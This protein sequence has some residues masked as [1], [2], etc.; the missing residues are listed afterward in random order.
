MGSNAEEPEHSRLMSFEANAIRLPD[1]DRPIYR[2]F[3][4][5]FFEAALT[6]NSG[7]LVLVAPSSWE[8]PL[9]SLAAGVQMQAPDFSSKM[10]H[11]YLK[12]TYAQCWSF[13][14]ESDALL[15]AY[16][17]VTRDPVMSRNMDP[18]NEGVQV[19]TTPRKLIAALNC[20]LHKRQ[21]ADFRFY[22]GA[23]EYVTNPVQNFFNLLNDVGPKAIGQGK[24]RAA[25]LLWKR[26]AFQHEAEVRII[27]VTENEVRG[28]LFYVETDLNQIFDDVRFDP[29]LAIF[30]RIEREKRARD[31]GYKGAFSISDSYQRILLQANLP[32]HWDEYSTDVDGA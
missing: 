10:L 18:K 7:S 12:P 8:D 23:V 15:R 6:V 29:R 25:S 21:T 28:G 24:N 26:L 30:E 19:R 32:K 20:F 2:I 1:L 9:E 22:V 4:L 3:P 31:F 17:R 14:G 11:S 5:W 27:L 16:S 13:E